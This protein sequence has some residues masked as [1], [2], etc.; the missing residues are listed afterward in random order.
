M[1]A[2][3]QNLQ[4]G[5]GQE[6]KPRCHCGLVAMELKSSKNN[7]RVF[8]RCSKQKRCDFFKW[9]DELNMN[10]GQVQQNNASFPA[11]VVC[12]KCNQVRWKEG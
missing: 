3:L 12:Y 5:N 7:G 1:D 10:G 4:A 6:T 9:D 8:W 11:D 2:F